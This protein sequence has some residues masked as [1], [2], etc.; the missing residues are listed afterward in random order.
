[1]YVRSGLFCQ[2]VPFER[3][4]GSGAEW[5]I[6][7]WKN[8]VR[9]GSSGKEGR[10]VREWGLTEDGSQPRV[11]LAMKMGILSQTKRRLCTHGSLVRLLNTIADPHERQDISVNLPFQSLVLCFGVLAFGLDCF[12]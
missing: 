2:F 4:E 5:L 12:T 1:M 7:H 9:L 11:L 6:R 8:I 3:R 10:I